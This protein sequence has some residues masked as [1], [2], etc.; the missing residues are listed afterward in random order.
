[1]EVSELELR[2]RCGFRQ[3][4]RGSDVEEVIAAFEA[5]GWREEIPSGVSGGGWMR[6]KCPECRR[7]ESVGKL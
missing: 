4:F 2:C 1:M 5:A 3:V 6:G 7:A